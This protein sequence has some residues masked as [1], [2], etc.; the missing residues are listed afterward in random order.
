MQPRS[1]ESY[2]QRLG[3][4]LFALYLI[5]YAT[6]VALSAFRN[7]LMAKPVLGG[8]NLAVVYGFG[9]IFAAFVLALAYMLLCRNDSDNERSSS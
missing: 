5:I 3:L 9:L 2:N 6:F 1:P 7:D 8:V 4:A